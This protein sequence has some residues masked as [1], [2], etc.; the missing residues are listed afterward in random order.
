MKLTE[1]QLETLQALVEG[2][3]LTFNDYGQLCLP[4]A[5]PGR[6]DNALS[7]TVRDVLIKNKLIERFDKTRDP[8][9]KGNGYVIS[10]KGRAA[11]S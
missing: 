3:M 4:V 10:E 5:L 7:G 11:L 2:A 8:R 1:A 6:F 9:R